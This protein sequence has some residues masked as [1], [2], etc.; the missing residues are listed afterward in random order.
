MCLYVR[1]ITA[2]EGR[3][4]QR[5]VRTDSDR[6]NVHH[7]PTLA[8]AGEGTRGPWGDPAPHE[9]QEHATP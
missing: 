2:P 5:I 4:L 6:I 9:F 1:S 7:V 8:K 3:R